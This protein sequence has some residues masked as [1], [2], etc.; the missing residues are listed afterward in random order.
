[1]ASIM[2]DTN[3]LIG[4]TCACP[5]C[6]DREVVQIPYHAFVMWQRGALIQDV[7]PDLSISKR[8]RL[9]TGMCDDCWDTMTEEE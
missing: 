4:V 5:M 1:M 6:G 2:T 7:M 8:E 3:T 9:M